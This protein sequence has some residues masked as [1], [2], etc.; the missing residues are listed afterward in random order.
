[1]ETMGER[2][3][4][5]LSESG[6]SAHAIANKHQGHPSRQAIHDIETDTTKSPGL[7]ILKVIAQELGLTVSQLIGESEA[8]PAKPQEDPDTEI[9]KA[10]LKHPELSQKEAEF[11]YKLL[12][13]YIKTWG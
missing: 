11:F 6:T 2:I 8:P 4:R 13:A 3:K 7:S 1:M 5:L 12:E 10:L 9:R